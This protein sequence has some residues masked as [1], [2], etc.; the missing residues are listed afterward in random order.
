MWESTRD[1]GEIACTCYCY[2]K[3]WKATQSIFSFHVVADSFKHCHIG[4]ETRRL[5]STKTSEGCVNFQIL[6]HIF[7]CPVVSSVKFFLQWQEDERQILYSRI[8]C[9]TVAA[10][11]AEFL[12][13]WRFAQAFF[14]FWDMY[15]SCTLVPSSETGRKA[16]SVWHNSAHSVLLRYCYCPKSSLSSTCILGIQHWAGRSSLKQDFGRVWRKGSLHFCAEIQT[17]YRDLGPLICFE[18]TVQIVWFVWG[19]IA[20]K[21]G[22]SGWWCE[23][24]SPDAGE[25]SDLDH[26][27]KAHSSWNRQ[28]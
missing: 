13:K 25:R 3:L 17:W 5:C 2:F 22:D 10:M 1:S 9:W 4:T 26:V 11:I 16:A 15:V 21:N 6:Y 12:N 14:A 24:S 7:S 23:L 19:D 18:T 20:G 28:Q 27:L 8:W